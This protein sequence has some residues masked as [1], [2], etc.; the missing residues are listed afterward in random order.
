M[1]GMT[2]FA[3][4]VEIVLSFCFASMRVVLQPVLTGFTVLIVGMQLGVVGIGETLDVADELLAAY[5]LHLVET[6]LTLGSCVAL[7]IWGKGVVRLFCTLAALVVGLEA[8]S[9]KEGVSLSFRVLLVLCARIGERAASSIA[10]R[11]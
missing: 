6:T 1:F 3:G 8:L 4:L 11:G 7:S 9:Q 5:P 10:N 2:A